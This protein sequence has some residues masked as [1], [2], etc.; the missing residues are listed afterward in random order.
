IVAAFVG[1]PYVEELLAHSRAGGYRVFP[2]ALLGITLFALG[3]GLLAAMVPAFTTARQNVVQA[4]VGPR[5][6]TRPRQR[7]IAVGIATIAIGT[8]VVLAGTYQIS[9][10][11]MLVGLILGELGLTLCTPAIVGLVA[12]VGR[13]LP[14]APRVALRDAAR[15]RAAAAPAISAV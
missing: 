13:I 4:P 1:R 6:V 9:A 15:N 8:A 14:V 10:T 11:I 7:W 5:G 2:L 12:R 3:T